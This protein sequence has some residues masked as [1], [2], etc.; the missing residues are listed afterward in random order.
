M[1]EMVWLR[2]WC[3]WGVGVGVRDRIG[4]E[5]LPEPADVTDVKEL[6]GRPVILSVKGFRL[7]AGTSVWA[8]TT[9]ERSVIAHLGHQTC[10][11]EVHVQAECRKSLPKKW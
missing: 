2:L 9:G 10:K 8:V 5:R 11:G 6:R 3:W 7:S 4:R 1:A